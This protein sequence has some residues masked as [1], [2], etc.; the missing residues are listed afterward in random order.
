M[1]LL[2]RRGAAITFDDLPSRSRVISDLE[3]EEI[4]DRGC[5]PQCS[6]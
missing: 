6:L 2:T 1:N 5:N 3:L 4:M